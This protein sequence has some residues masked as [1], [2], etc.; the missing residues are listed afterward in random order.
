[1]TFPVSE[2][3]LMKRNP[4]F[5]VTKKRWQEVALG[6]WYG[7]FAYVSGGLGI[8]EIGCFSSGPVGYLASYILLSYSTKYSR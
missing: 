7:A 1:M 2:E 4:S 3:R 8:S 6:V 5:H